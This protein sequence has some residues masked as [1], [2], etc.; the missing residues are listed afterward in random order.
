M[1]Q[2]E[3]SGVL[4]HQLV[5]KMHN[6]IMRRSRFLMSFYC[7]SI[8]E[9]SLARGKGQKKSFFLKKEGNG[10]LVIGHE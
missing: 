4:Q 10:H 3:G 8:G 9:T 7:I 6:E 1:W 2:P 5:D